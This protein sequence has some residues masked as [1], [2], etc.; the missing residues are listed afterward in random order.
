VHSLAPNRFSQERRTARVLREITVTRDPTAGGERRSPITGRHQT[1]EDPVLSA[2]QKLRTGR[3]RGKR[4]GVLHRVG[5][6]HHRIGRRQP[7][8]GIEGKRR[9][10]TGQIT[11]PLRPPA[12]QHVA[13]VDAVHVI[14]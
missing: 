11:F 5:G 8:P 2:G 9:V 3:G 4:N 7:W 10:D 13:G 12:S 14:R 1:K 6:L